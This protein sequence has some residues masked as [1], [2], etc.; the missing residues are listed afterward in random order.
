MK[1]IAQVALMLLAVA[2]NNSGSHSSAT[3]KKTTD[4]LMDA[5]MQGHNVGMAK[6]NKVSEAQKKIQQVIDSIS[7]LPAT[8]Q[9]QSL[10]YKTQLDAMLVRLR[11]AA[12]AMNR[13]ME[14]FNLDSDVN[15]TE[16]RIKYLESERTKVSNVKDSMIS[17]LRDADSLLKRF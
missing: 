10:A 17:S 5:V 12:D 16:L 3:A 4:S 8:L 15:N 7:S 11:N 14:E 2:C 6:M 13:W 9:K 1:Q